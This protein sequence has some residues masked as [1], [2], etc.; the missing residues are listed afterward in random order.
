MVRLERSTEM[1]SELRIE[2]ITIPLPFRL[3]HVNCF[4]AEGSRGWTIID[5]GLH[6][7]VTKNMWKPV[8]EKH[9]IKDMVITHYHPDHF[10]YAGELQ[11]LTGAEVWMTEIDKE[12]GLTY[13]ETNSLD[14]VKENYKKCGLPFQLASEL[15]S[16]EESFNGKVKP[17]PEVQHIIEE[18]MKF[19]F[20]NHEYEVIFTPGHSDGLF[21]LYNKENG[22]LL[23]T[24]HV[25]PKISPNISYWFRG[26]PNPLQAYINSL[27]KI[28][29]LNADYVIPSHFK[30]F[31]NANKRIEELLA[32]HEERLEVTY[33]SIRKPS[34]IFE[35]TTEMFNHLN[36]HEMRFAIG[37]TLAHLEY[38]VSNDQCKKF[39]E[40]TTWYY[41]AI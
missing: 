19:Q 37:E 39:I 35:V 14:V 23:S 13:W 26:D 41:E 27:E 21:V 34:T 28:K 36:L 30:P 8:I 17:Y 16:D 18:G 25:L 24:D 10:G 4:L 38:L 22:I 12:S 5:A 3:N 15:T 32:H 29:K 31:K 9:D 1:L 20:G 33:K 40:G 2:Q 6:T 7:M 11:K